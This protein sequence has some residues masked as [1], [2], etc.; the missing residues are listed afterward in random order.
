MVKRRRVENESASVYALY[1]SVTEIYEKLRFAS[2]CV[3]LSP[4]Q[5]NKGDRLT[6]EDFANCF[7]RPFAIYQ[8]T[9]D[10]H[11]G[12]TERKVWNDR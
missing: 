4:V 10:R 11:D 1:V 9:K 12:G 8:K 5:R 3:N 6:N 2:Y 7:T